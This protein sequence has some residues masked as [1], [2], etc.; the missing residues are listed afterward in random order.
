VSAWAGIHYFASRH[1]FHAPGEADD[2]PVFTWPEGNAWLVRKLAA[3]LG[4]RLLLARS[5]RRVQALRHGV[6]VLV[7]DERSGRDESW[8]AQAVVLAVPLFV[9][10]RLLDPAPPALAEAI[11]G[12]L[13]AP[14]LVAN[15]LLDA[16]LLDRPTGSPPSWDNV[17][18][19]SA[20][21]GYVD[22]SHQNL[23]PTPGPTVLT[24][25][26]ALPANERAALGA[27]DWRPWARR[28]ID[29][30]LPAHPDLLLRVQRIDLA[31]HGHA[32]AVP[33]PGLRSNPALAALA[34][35]PPGER[36]QF[37]HADLSA[38]SVF[39]EAF[40]HGVRAGRATA[41]RLRGR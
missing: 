6:Q 18:Y 32:M 40:F 33:V 2:S 23:D 11:A 13:R 12:M 30:L 21:L 5:V 35:P 38:Y 31:R 14:W 26:W 19:G 36:V 24:A 25:Y 10:A 7:R 41:R 28:V 16:P 15:L 39:E 27:D 17:R 29:D 37:A 1:G 22:A 8:S 9:A 3:P 20:S 4:E 34:Q